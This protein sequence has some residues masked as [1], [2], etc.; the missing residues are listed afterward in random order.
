MSELDRVPA[1]IDD[2]SGVYLWTGVE[3]HRA[4]HREWV[5]MARYRCEQ[6]GRDVTIV[7]FERD[8][9]DE[10]GLRHLRT[11][12]RSCASISQWLVTAPA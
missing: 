3:E 1:V 9:S 6:C 11:C 4:Q 12:P 2:G 5:F 10:R 8:L 7:R